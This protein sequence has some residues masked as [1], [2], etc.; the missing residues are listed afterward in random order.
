VVRLQPRS[1]A[2]DVPAGVLGG[3]GSGLS[4]RDLGT[5]ARNPKGLSR[6]AGTRARRR[7][8]LALGPRGRGLRLGSASQA[9]EDGLQLLG[10]V[11][12]GPPKSLAFVAEFPQRP[13][14]RLVLLTAGPLL[15]PDLSESLHRAVVLA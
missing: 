8:G 7:P 3:T 4:R 12:A 5:R 14:G 13:R 1:D 11:L 15:R 10:G 9:A 6:H 2:R